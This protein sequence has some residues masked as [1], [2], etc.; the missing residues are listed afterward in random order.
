MKMLAVLDGDLR[1][2]LHVDAKHGR[3]AA[4]AK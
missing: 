1:V 3:E 4:I 2:T